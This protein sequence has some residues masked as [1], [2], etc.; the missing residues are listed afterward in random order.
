MRNFQPSN[1]QHHLARP[2]AAEL[3]WYEKPLWDT[4][5]A[6]WGSSAPP[7]KLPKPGE[8]MGPSTPD[9]TPVA[10][11]TVAYNAILAELDKKYGKLT[12]VGWRDSVGDGNYVYRQYTDGRIFIQKSGM[13][14]TPVAPKILGGNQQPT[15]G[16]PP[17]WVLPVA[18]VGGAGVIGAGIYFWPKIRA[19]MKRR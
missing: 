17:P 9:G 10:K 12:G 2:N 6:W 16:G 19:K 5:S 11:G 15:V 7:A 13:G 4:I 14:S 8:P 1:P 18:I 3:A